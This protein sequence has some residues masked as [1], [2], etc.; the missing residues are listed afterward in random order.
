MMVLGVLAGGL[1]SSCTNDYEPSNMRAGMLA[2]APEMR[3]YSGQHYWGAPTA[4]R[5]AN[6]NGNQWYATWDCPENVWEKHTDTDNVLTPEDLAAIKKLLSPG[7]ETHNTIVLPWANYWVQQVYTGEDTYPGMNK[8]NPPAQVGNEILGAE[9]MNK[10]IAWNPHTE[11]IYGDPANNW[12]PYEGTVYYEHVNNFNSASNNTTFTEDWN[13]THGNAKIIGTT[14]MTDMPTSGIDPDKQFGFHETWGTEHDYNNY[15]IVEYKG[16]YYVGFDYEAHKYD[17]TSNN[18]GEAYNIERD[19]NFTDWIVRISPAY[20]KGTTPPGNP[21]GIIEPSNPSTPEVCDK[22][23]DA[24]HA[25]GLCPNED[26]NNEECHPSPCPKDQC[27]HTRHP[28]YGC[29]TCYEEGVRNDCSLMFRS[30][31]VETGQYDR[32]NDLIYDPLVD[33]PEY[34]PLPDNDTPSQNPGFEKGKD[35]VEVNLALDQKNHNLLESHLSIHVRTA[36]NVEVFIPV[37][38]QY[39]CAEDDMDIVIKHSEAFVHGG[40]YQTKYEIGENTV[41]LNVDFQADGIRIWTEGIDQDVIDYCWD[42]YKDGIT[43]E[44]WNYFNDPKTSLPYISMEE[45]KGYLDQATVRFIDKIPGAYINA[46]GKLNGKYS[47]DNP[48]GKD[49][50]VTPQDQAD[51]FNESYEGPHFNGSD[52][53]DI[54]QRK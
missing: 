19:W 53:N 35:E 51:S 10:L 17:Q 49:F 28:D 29:G 24:P 47:G 18:E 36:T 34:G 30:W 16:Y 48:D 33:G 7:Q 26:C 39:Y 5:S 38:A 43:F 1:L 23:G 52:N 2:K 9:H 45:L 15:L 14:L 6:L 37:P 8:Q 4:T 27:G 40:P 46:F 50:H 44:I 21:G 54:Y 11:T 42:N 22:C 31:L 25:P 3:A 13:G 20:P 32:N 12:Q 41:T